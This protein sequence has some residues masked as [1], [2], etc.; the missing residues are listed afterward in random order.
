LAA[1]RDGRLFHLIEVL[2]IAFDDPLPNEVFVFSAPAGEAIRPPHELY[3]ARATPPG[4]GGVARCPSR[5]SGSTRS[6]RLAPGGSLTP[7]GTRPPMPA[8]VV[9]RD[10]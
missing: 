7:A 10:A 1:K 8:T 3:P 2:A 9:L 6:R 4:R 5:S